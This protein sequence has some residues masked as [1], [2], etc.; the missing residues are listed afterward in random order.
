MVGENHPG[1]AG[2]SNPP[3]GLD[4]ERR[5][6]S[7]LQGQELPDLELIVASPQHAKIPLRQH[8]T[9]L[10]IL[11]FVPG[12]N[13]GHAW[14]GGIPTPDASNHYGY[15]RH[16][17]EFRALGAKVMAVASQPDEHLRRIGQSLLAG[18]LLLSDPALDLAHALELPTDDCGLYRRVAL[19]AAGTRVTRML[20]ALENFQAGGQA[21][22][23]LSQL[24]QMGAR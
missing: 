3:V 9:G 6:A 23:V 20:P 10:T 15:V 11:Y 5:L 1:L 17:Y 22:R 19:I 4:A 7:R 13:E 18:H 16:H 14:S 12:E 2:H 8:L 24:T 21:R